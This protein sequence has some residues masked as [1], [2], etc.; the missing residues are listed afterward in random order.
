MKEGYEGKEHLNA[1]LIFVRH[2][3]NW[4]RSRV[5]SYIILSFSPDILLQL[6]F[7]VLFKLCQM[8]IFSQLYKYP[9]I[10]LASDTGDWL[11]AYGCILFNLRQ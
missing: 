6:L 11:P 7:K 10:N 3:T 5:V 9:H 1:V 2:S 8:C 4:E